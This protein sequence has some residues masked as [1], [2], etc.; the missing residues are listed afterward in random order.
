M[1]THSNL[2]V[3]LPPQVLVLEEEVVEEEVVVALVEAVE[4]SP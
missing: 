2:V 1:A 3:P 4:L